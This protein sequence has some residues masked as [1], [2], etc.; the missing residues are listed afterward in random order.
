MCR[1][2]H[3]IGKM[4]NRGL[5]EGQVGP[6]SILLVKCLFLWFGVVGLGSRRQVWKGRRWGRRRGGGGKIEWQERRR[7]ED[8]TGLF[9]GDE[10][11]GQRMDTL[12]HPYLRVPL[13]VSRR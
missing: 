3:L 7:T 12:P 2:G 1:E 8:P 10:R 11:V 5:E 4:H 6:G 13:P 9:T